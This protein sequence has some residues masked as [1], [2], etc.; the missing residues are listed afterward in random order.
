MTKDDLQK[1]IAE[2][3]ATEAN[4]NQQLQQIVG[5]I[6]RTVGAREMAQHLLN[7]MDKPAETKVKRGRTKAVKDGEKPMHTDPGNS[8]AHGN[9]ISE[10]T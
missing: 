8:G 4:L 2:C 5:Q 9:S 6:N 3:N 10:A 7:E 1:L